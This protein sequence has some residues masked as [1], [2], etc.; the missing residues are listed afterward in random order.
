MN[1]LYVDRHIEQ[2]I[3]SLQIRTRAKTL[4]IVRLLHTY[5]Y[6]LGMPYCKMIRRNL[7]E[8]RIQSAEDV[9][10]FF[11]YSNQDAVI[12]HGYIKQTRRIPRRELDTAL[13]KSNTLAKR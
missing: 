7:Y 12:L 10:L 3:R 4:R 1:V 2:F 6:D 13:Q 9:R 11:T 8:L 5:G